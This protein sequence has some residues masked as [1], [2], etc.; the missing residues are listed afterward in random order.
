MKILKWVG[1]IVGVLIVG[2]LAI[3]VITP[4]F[5]YHNSVTV[6]APVEK[7]Y[8]VFT[9]ESKMS[10]WLTGLQRI[11][12]VSGAPLE[13]GSKWKLVFD[14]GGRTIEVLEEVTAVD[15]NQR[16][17]FNIDTEPFAGTVDIRFAAIDSTTC[18]IDATS[19]VDGKNM[20][21]KSVLALSKSMMTDRA[22]EQYGLLKRLIET[23]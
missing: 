17:A 8:S 15:P 9:D 12:N 14:E 13:A 3:G 10:E 22:Q 18:K 19:T 23:D 2:F 11:E 7:A 4:D 1:I 21:W 5:S 6:N 16:F 20:V